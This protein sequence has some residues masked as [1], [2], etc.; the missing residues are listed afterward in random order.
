[1]AK[2]AARQQQNNFT[3][4]LG[5]HDPNPTLIETVDGKPVTY[6]QAVEDKTGR[7]REV[8]GE[9][10]TWVLDKVRGAV[11]LAKS[12]ERAE[13]K[14]LGYEERRRIAEIQGGS[15]E[16]AAA[17][18]AEAKLEQEKLK[19]FNSLT[20]TTVMNGTKQ[21]I[22]ELNAGVDLFVNENRTAAQ[23]RIADAQI[24]GR[25]DVAGKTNV[26]RE[27]IAERMASVREK[28]GE[29]K[30]VYQTFKAKL[31]ATTREKITGMELDS[32][33]ARDTAAHR[34]EVFETALRVA[35]SADKFGRVPKPEEVERK[36]RM[37]L[38]GFETSAL[39]LDKPGGAAAAG[40]NPAAAPK[41]S[42]D[43]LED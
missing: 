18:A 33:K 26:S 10:K 20:R 4:E 22:A 39:D 9:L 19:G 7:Y 37:F 41:P 6:A 40:V 31:D 2:V 8:T 28:L 43:F 30:T 35:G 32:R 12:T 11:S 17:I 16:T 1:M 5:M 13:E 29:S 34:A 25:A 15:R 42:L 3:K 21:A 14:R 27:K 36:A 38:Q 23:E 24:A